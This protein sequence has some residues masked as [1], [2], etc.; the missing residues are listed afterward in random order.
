M[1]HKTTT[2]LPPCNAKAPKLTVAL[3]MSHRLN[4]TPCLYNVT[5]PGSGVLGNPST[6][7]TSTKRGVPYPTPSRRVVK[8]LFISA[9]PRSAA[10][11]A[12]WGVRTLGKRPGAVWQADIAS[13]HDPR[14]ATNQRNELPSLHITFQ[15]RLYM[16][17][18]F[19][20]SAFHFTALLTFSCVIPTTSGSI[21]RRIAKGVQYAS[22]NKLVLFLIHLQQ[23]ISAGLDCGGRT[24]VAH[25]FGLNCSQLMGK[26]RFTK[27]ASHALS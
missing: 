23:L 25:L 2:P 24:P 3:N 27:R 21:V 13:F 12:C 20:S 15:Q 14:V 26:I 4:R 5:R 9:Y 19:F 11:G 18:F 8:I 16:C 6:S 22:I 10:W 1:G 17:V 7:R